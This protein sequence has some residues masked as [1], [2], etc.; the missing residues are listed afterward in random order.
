MDTATALKIAFLVLRDWR[1]IVITIAVILY[2]SF[3]ISIITYRKKPKKT[4]VKKKTTAPA[5]KPAAD[6]GDAGK[7]SGGGAAE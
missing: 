6:A 5:P 4:P 7:E 1:V 2:L 3:Y